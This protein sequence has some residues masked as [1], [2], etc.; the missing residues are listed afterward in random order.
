MYTNSAHLYTLH[1]VGLTTRTA[2]LTPTQACAVL[3]AIMSNVIFFRRKLQKRKKKGKSRSA[4]SQLGRTAKVRLPLTK[5][6][7]I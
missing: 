7:I 2:T 5:T 3:S 1:P 4:A 6:T